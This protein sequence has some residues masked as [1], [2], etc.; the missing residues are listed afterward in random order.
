M[1]EFIFAKEDNGTDGRYTA[2]ID[3]K[4]GIAEIIFFHKGDNV[5]SADHTYANELA[6]TGAA[7][8]LVEYMIKD[9]RENGLKIIPACSYVA[10]L[11]T[12]HPEWSDVIAA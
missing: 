9:A 3:G 1:T 10:K 7:G 2:T 12:R 11:Y 8:A 4:E 5:I 6:G